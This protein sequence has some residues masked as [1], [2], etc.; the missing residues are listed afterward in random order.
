LPV[1]QVL[2][3]TALAYLLNTWAL[4]RSSPLPVAV[5]ITLQPAVAT[6]GAAL[7]LREVPGWVEGAGFVAGLLPTVRGAADSTQGV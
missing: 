5:S 4:R 3:G 2:A 6:A 7:F 1:R